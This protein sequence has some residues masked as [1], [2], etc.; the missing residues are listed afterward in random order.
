MSHSLSRPGRLDALVRIVVFSIAAALLPLR[1]ASAMVVISGLDEAQEANVRALLPLATAACKTGRWRIQRLFRDADSHIH[2]ALQA[3]GFYSAS[4]SKQL[5]WEETCWR[6]TIAIEPGEPVRLDDIDIAV[7]GPAGEDPAVLAKL[8]INKPQA[9][10]I[11]NHSHYEAY[12]DKLRNA[13]LERGYFDAHFLQHQVLVDV[14][15]RS[16]RMTLRLDS[17]LRYHFG[18][19]TFTP[20]ILRRELLQQFGDIEPGDPYDARNVAMLS[21]ALS[22]SGYFGSVEVVTGPLDPETRTVPI[23]VTL[24]PGNSRTYTT[25]IGFSTD[26]GPQVRL[27]YDDRRRNER[28]AQFESRLFASEVTSELSATYRWPHR[29]PR[30]EWFTVGAGFQQENT[31]SSDSDTYKLGIS[32]TR[33]LSGK[34]LEKPYLELVYE[35]FTVGSDDGHSRLLIGGIN[36]ESVTGRELGRIKRGRMLSFDIRGAAEQLGSDTSFLQL[37]ARGKWIRSIDA[38]TRILVRTAMGATIKESLSELPASVRFFSGGDRS[39][40]AYEFESLG[41]RDSFGDVIGGSHLIEA[42]IEIDRVVRGNWAIAA[43]FDTGSAFNA[44]PEFSSGTGLGLRWQ[45]PIGPIRL[46]FAT[47]LD[48]SDTQLRVHFSMGPDL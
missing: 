36:W 28:G 9:G 4:L 42:S 12:R 44:D 10:D 39:V 29:D 35:D 37:R 7:E 19:I 43:F 31:D 1:N 25:G 40:R 21:A 41:P 15:T 46:D 27:G 20:G 16:A 18:E 24:T 34:W 32:R 23:T 33:N 8:A 13:A 30:K 45:S 17:G 48:D 47:P 26:T 2:R 14:P 11:L 6:A 5:T 3:L 22:D 38:K